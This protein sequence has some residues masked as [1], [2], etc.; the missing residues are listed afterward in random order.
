MYTD[1]V[2]ITRDDNNLFS[3]SM[4][5]EAKSY[6]VMFQHIIELDFA[7][8]HYSCKIINGVGLL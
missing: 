7:G 1:I 2:D 4:H 6:F 3:V 5:A 8:F